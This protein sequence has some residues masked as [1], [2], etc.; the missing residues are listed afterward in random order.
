M[1]VPSRVGLGS[2]WVA[3]VGLKP[4][5]KHTLCNR[6]MSLKK[7]K[8][9]LNSVK[10]FSEREMYDILHKEFEFGILTNRSFYGLAI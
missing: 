1:L 8:F 4:L 5:A 10:T 3:L 2:C 9:I 6:C 7:L